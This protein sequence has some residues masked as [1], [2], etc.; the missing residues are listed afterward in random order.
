M[1]RNLTVPYSDGDHAY[2]MAKIAKNDYT[3]SVQFSP[4]GLQFLVP[5]LLTLSY[6][7]CDRR[8]VLQQLEVVYTSNDLLKI[9]DLLPSINNRIDKT[10]TGVIRH[11]SRY[12]IAY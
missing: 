8:T 11:F 4:E 7:N 3:N 6:S 5:A 12:A 1:N 9:L 10:T 2:S